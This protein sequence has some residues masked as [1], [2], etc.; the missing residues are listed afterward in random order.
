MGALRALVLAT[1]ITACRPVYE[2]PDLSQGAQIAAIIGDFRR[3][4]VSTADPYDYHIVDPNKAQIN[5]GDREMQTCL[6]AQIGFANV[7][8]PKFCHIDGS[9]PEVRNL[10][11]LTVS[12][13]H[14]E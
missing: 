1:S 2:A 7:D 13:T 4:C 6:A 5:I 8:G 14:K 9:D 3:R 12:C 10:N 11:V